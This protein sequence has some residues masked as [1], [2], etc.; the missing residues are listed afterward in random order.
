MNEKEYTLCGYEIKN[1]LMMA[2]GVFSDVPEL[3]KIYEDAGIGVVNTKSI[4]IKAK[5]PNEFNYFHPELS[6]LLSEGHKITKKMNECLPKMIMIRMKNS[7]INSMGLPNEDSN[8]K[9][10]AHDAYWW[11]ERI[12]KYIFSVLKCASVAT[13]WGMLEDYAKIVRI[14]ESFFDIFE[15]NVSCPNTKH[16]IIGYDVDSMEFLLKNIKSNKPLIFK[17]PCYFDKDSLIDYTLKDPEIGGHLFN[18]G[19]TVK[20]PTKIDKE[21]LREMLELLE[22]YDIPCVTSHNTI[23]VVHPLLATPRGGLSGRPIHDIAVEQARL[24]SKHSEMEIIGSGGVMNSNDVMD[25]LKIRNVKAVQLASGLFQHDIPHLFVK[26]LLE[27][28]AQ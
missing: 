9:S 28:M 15:I 6:R 13:A 12:Q 25:F 11:K 24:I 18:E 5:Q 4:L 8:E 19:I 1:P 26:D 10:H 17:L 3:L 14:L 22:K 16:N 21:A 23:P 27:G 7:T 20:L 2:S